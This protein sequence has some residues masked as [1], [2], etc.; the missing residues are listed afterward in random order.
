MRGEIFRGWSSKLSRS[1]GVNI[2]GMVII[3]DKSS[4]YE[5][6]VNLSGVVI[7]VEHQVGGVKPP[8][9]GHQTRAGMIGCK[10][11]MGCQQS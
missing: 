8:R 1:E 11:F 7:T 3:V 5:R 9:G 6:D 2:W 10:S 4:R